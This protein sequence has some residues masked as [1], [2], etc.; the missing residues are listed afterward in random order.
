M[1]HAQQPV[2]TVKSHQVPTISIGDRVSVAS[3]GRSCWQ[4]VFHFGF[5]QETDVPQALLQ[6]KDHGI[7]LE[8]MRTSYF[9]SRELV[10]PKFNNEG[11]AMWRER[12]FANL[13][14]NA[15]GAADFLGLPPNRVVEVGAQVEI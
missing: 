12:L 13:H 14:H 1:L 2:L 5:K 4:V 3:L 6:L 15:S 11:M 10:L 7:E 9:L 8:E